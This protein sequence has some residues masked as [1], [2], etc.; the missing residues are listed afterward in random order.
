M[1]SSCNHDNQAA[2]A[3]YVQYVVTTRSLQLM[4]QNSYLG[5]WFSEGSKSGFCWFSVLPCLVSLLHQWIPGS[6]VKD[7]SCVKWRRFMYFGGV[8]CKGCVL[9]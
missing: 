5:E 9:F 8:W 2:V 7:C 6:V 1:V 3:V 4:V